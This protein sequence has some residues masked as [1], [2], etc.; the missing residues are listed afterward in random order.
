M[1]FVHGLR[2]TS[3]NE[4]VKFCKD[5]FALHGIPKRLY[6]DNGSQYCAAEFRNFAMTL[7]FEHITS[8]P[9][10]PQNNAFAEGVPVKEC[11]KDV[12]TKTHKV[13]FD[14]ETNVSYSKHNV[15]VEDTF[16][17][18]KSTRNVKKPCRLIEEC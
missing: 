6:S 15:P 11:S 9:H 13:T 14:N 3:C 17:T 18:R 16:A 10:Y 2:S 4:V 1:P 12:N 8:S 7:E 5:M